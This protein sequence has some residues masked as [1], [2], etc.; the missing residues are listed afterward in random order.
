MQSETSVLEAEYKAYLLLTIPKI[1]EMSKTFVQSYPE[2][3]EHPLATAEET[4]GAMKTCT[5][6][7]AE[8]TMPG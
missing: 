7:P 8:P 6:N 1:V 5:K 2:P 4:I 3:L